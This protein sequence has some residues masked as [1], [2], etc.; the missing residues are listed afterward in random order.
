MGRRSTSPG[1]ASAVSEERM[2]ST[3]QSTVWHRKVRLAF[4]CSAPGSK[5]ASVSTWK[6]LQMPTTGPPAPR[7]AR[8]SCPGTGRCR[9]ARSR[10]WFQLAELDLVRLDD[11]VGE[12]PATHLVDLRPSR[13]FVGCLDDE[14]DALADAHV[15]DVVVAK[16]W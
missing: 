8:S 4:F 16:C 6:P 9:R 5:P 12:Q 14:P 1:A 2:V 10:R 13:G 15:R 3:R 11:G 7:R